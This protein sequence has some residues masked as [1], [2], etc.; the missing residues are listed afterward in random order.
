MHSTAKQILRQRAYKI[1][2][3]E[4]THTEANNEQAYI[5]FR[6]G[7]EHYAIEAKFLSEALRY[8]APTPV[9]Y[10]PHYLPGLVYL[11]GRFISLLD[12][13]AFLQ[14]A[15]TTDNHQRS[16]MIMSDSKMEFALVI[17]EVIGRCTEL[18]QETLQPLAQGGQFSHPELIAG[19]T[20]DTLIVLDGHKLLAHPALHIYQTV[21]SW[22]SAT[23]NY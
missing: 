13:A 5:E 11:R 2:Q 17:D 3:P 23:A 15:P 4:Q 6:L 12:L 16:L 21:E 1:A 18:S 10:L 9:P 22:A 14:L 19:V 20:E 8:R 7:Q